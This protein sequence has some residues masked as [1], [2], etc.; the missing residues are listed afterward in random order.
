M[1]GT[2]LIPEGVLL[3]FPKMTL[4]LKELSTI[5]IESEKENARAKTVELL[6]NDH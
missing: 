5:L 6:L 3:S 1:F 4:L 2:C